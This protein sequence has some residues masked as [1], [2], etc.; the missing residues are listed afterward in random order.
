[1]RVLTHHDAV[2]DA[3]TWLEGNA[4]YT[5]RGGN[6]VAQVEVRGLIAAAFTHRD[7]RAGDPGL[8]GHNVDESAQSTA[9]AT[10]GYCPNN[11]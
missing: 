1:L 8:A 9:I 4:A 2:A 5:R 6:G 10:R 3:L 11:G 7:S